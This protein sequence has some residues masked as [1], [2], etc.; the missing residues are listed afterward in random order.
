MVSAIICVNWTIT[1][2]YVGAGPDLTH[3]D[4]SHILIA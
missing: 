1:P 3:H 2:K 4:E